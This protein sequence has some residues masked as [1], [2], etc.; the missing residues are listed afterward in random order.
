V[1]VFEYR[2]LLE[3]LRKLLSSRVSQPATQAIG[4]CREGQRA[5]AEAMLC[6]RRLSITEMPI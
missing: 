3:E 5:F 1:F 4:T 2:A 6:L